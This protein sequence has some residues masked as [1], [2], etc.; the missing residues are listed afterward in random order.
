MK[1]RDGATALHFA[2][3]KGYYEIVE[4]LLEAGATPKDVKKILFPHALAESKGHDRI[5]ELLRRHQ[6]RVEARGD[7]VQVERAGSGHED[8]G[9]E[10][11][12]ME[13]LQGHV[14]LV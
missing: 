9:E 6:I 3:E 4:L 12:S 11:S 13:H 1:N 2:A 10:G 7:R 14:S 8:G 5:A